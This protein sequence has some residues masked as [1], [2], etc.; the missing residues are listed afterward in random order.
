MAK[1]TDL[2]VLSGNTDVATL[3]ALKD[4]LRGNSNI[5]DY[6]FEEVDTSNAQQDILERILNATDDD[7][8]ENI[9]GALGWQN[10]LGVP[11]IIQSFR[12]LPTEKKGDGPPFYLLCEVINE[13]TQENWPLSSGGC[14]GPAQ[15][16]RHAER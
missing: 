10:Y 7:E 1:S 5:N 6:D 2:V 11:M 13:I 3:D 12:P 16:S 14:F 9:G 8:A 4:V 15:N